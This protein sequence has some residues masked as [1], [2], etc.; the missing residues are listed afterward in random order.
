M[1]D[2]QAIASKENLSLMVPERGDL[3]PGQELEVGKIMQETKQEIVEKVIQETKP[4]LVR[5][6]GRLKTLGSF[7]TPDE[8]Q[9]ITVHQMRVVLGGE[10]V[11][12]NQ[13]VLEAIASD[14]Q[15]KALV[16]ETRG[17]IEKVIAKMAE[18]EEEWAKE[19]PKIIQNFLEL[20]PKA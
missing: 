7:A 9:N 18:A 14:E 8:V 20:F 6:L 19:T 4:A 3:E 5:N 11:L 12:N 10:D 17:E 13:A 16:K 2:N 1:P 15:I